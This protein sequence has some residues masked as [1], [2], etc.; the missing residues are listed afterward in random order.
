M[1]VKEYYFRV[2][3]LSSRGNVVLLLG[4]SAPGNSKTG[5]YFILA[6]FMFLFI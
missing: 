3:A 5:D 2:S 6:G 1:A 4:W